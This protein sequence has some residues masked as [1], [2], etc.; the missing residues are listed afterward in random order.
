MFQPLTK[1]YKVVLQGCP[2]VG[3]TILVDAMKGIPRT[4][5][6][7]PTIGCDITPILHKD[8]ILNMWDLSG[9]VQLENLGDEYFTDAN[10]VVQVSRK[11]WRNP[12]LFPLG[13]Q[14]NITIN[15]DDYQE[16]IDHINKILDMISERLN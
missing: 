12:I 14:P 5:K 8:K 15:L 7:I 4:L 6:Y 16:P 10:L 1:R 11:G 2:G 13:Y 3:K 9:Q